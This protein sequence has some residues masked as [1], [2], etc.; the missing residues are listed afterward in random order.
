MEKCSQQYLV[1][2]EWEGLSEKFVMMDD[3]RASQE[4]LERVRIQRGKLR[5]YHT[6]VD[7]VSFWDVFCVLM[8]LVASGANAT[9]IAKGHP[10]YKFRLLQEQRPHCSKHPTALPETWLFDKQ[11]KSLYHIWR[12]YYNI[13]KNGSSN[14]LPEILL[15]DTMQHNF[16]YCAALKIKWESNWNFDFLLHS[17][18][19]STCVSLVFVIIIISALQNFNSIKPLG[20]PRSFLVVISILVQSGIAETSRSRYGLLTLWMFCSIVLVTFYTGGH[21]KLRDKTSAG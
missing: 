17:F 6:S 16:A 13:S 1:N 5:D 4:E 2:S 8:D 11:E 18:S 7:W 12:T 10:S 15:K 19:T 9:L 21:Y 14:L 3:F 20:W